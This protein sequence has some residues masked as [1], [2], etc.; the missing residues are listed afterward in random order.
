KHYP[1]WTIDRDIEL[2]LL[3]THDRIIFQFPLYWY[4]AP[5]HL[6]LWEDTVLE[7]ADEFL[8]CTELGI[9]ET[10]GVSAKDYQAGV[11]EEY[12]IA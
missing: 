4:S 8:R 6:K 5:A 11:P 10:T 9:V 3:K 7:H 1:D 2:E 12:H